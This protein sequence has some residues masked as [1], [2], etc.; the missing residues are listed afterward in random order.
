MEGDPAQLPH[1]PVGSWD[2]HSAWGYPP[3]PLQGQVA[4]VSL[5]PCPTTL[6]RASLQSAQPWCQVP[7]RQPALPGTPELGDGWPRANITHPALMTLSLTPVPGQCSHGCWE[8]LLCP[9][10]L[11]NQGPEGTG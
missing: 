6:A 10:S 7:G 4:S 5:F 9:P 3:V 8:L 1:A 11:G 2:P